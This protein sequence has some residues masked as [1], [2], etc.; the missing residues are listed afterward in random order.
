MLGHEQQHLVVYKVT[1]LLERA[2]QTQLQGLTDL[3]G[4]RWGQHEKRVPWEACDD[5]A[6]AHL[7][8]AKVRH[9]EWLSARRNQ[10]EKGP[11]K[12]W[13]SG[14]EVQPPCPPL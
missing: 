7:H 13:V 6:L 8:R 3:S 10:G 1:V 11:K 4:W 9:W 12:S 5:S 14:S 2:S